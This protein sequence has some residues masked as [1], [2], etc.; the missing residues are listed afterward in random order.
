MTAAEGWHAAAFPLQLV[1][2]SVVF[3]VADNDNL[4][5]VWQ[6]PQP[7]VKVVHM[8]DAPVQG[9]VPGMHKYVTVGH[10]QVPMFAM[11]VADA[12]NPET[13]LAVLACCSVLKHGIR[14]PLRQG[15]CSSPTRLSSARTESHVTN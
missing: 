10:L 15:Q 9:E 6:L 7:S 13:A 3:M 2:I 5:P 1:P 11:C 14:A 8:L 12:N 4:H